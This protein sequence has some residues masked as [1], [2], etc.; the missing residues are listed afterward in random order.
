MVWCVS[1][2]LPSEQIISQRC[3]DYSLVLYNDRGQNIDY[4]DHKP[5]II[6]Y[7]AKGLN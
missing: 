6:Q 5:N 7:I 3:M 2:R 4:V 1:I